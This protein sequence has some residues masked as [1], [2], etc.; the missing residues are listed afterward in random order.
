MEKLFVLSSGLYYTHVRVIETYATTN[1]KFMNPDIFT[2]WHDWLS[3][4]RFIMMRRIIE[5]SNGHL[6]NSQKILQSSKLSCDTCS[7]GKLII[8]PSP[9]K[10]K[11]ESPT[12][13]E[14]IH[15]D[16]CGPINPTNGSFRYFVVLIDAFSRWSHMRLLSS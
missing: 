15:D 1:L 12:F 11:T 2:I 13:F 5:D 10:M 4:S 6:L 8:R 16:I 9:A 14:R 7:Q 3:H